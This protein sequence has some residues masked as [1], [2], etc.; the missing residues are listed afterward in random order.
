MHRVQE[1]VSPAKESSL[2]SESESGS[3]CQ[4]AFL[5]QDERLGKAGAAIVTI[6]KAEKDVDDFDVRSRYLLL[7]LKDCAI[8]G[9]ACRY[10]E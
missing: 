4:D 3:G 10:L 8:A 1:S 6:P 7:I 2:I 5:S 9:I